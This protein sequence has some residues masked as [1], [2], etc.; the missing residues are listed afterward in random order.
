VFNP[1]G[2]TTI[3]FEGRQEVR[4]KQLLAYRFASPSYGC[5]GYFDKRYVPARTGRVLVEDPG[6][7]MIQYEE[8]AG[9]PQGIR[10]AI[11]PGSN[12]VELR[13][14]RRCFGSAAVDE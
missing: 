13:Q 6:G 7:S 10:G 2:P 5:F 8:E 4:G 14:D 11:L 3:D 1:E 12:F 9:L